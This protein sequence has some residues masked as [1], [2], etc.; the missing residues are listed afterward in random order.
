MANTYASGST[1]KLPLQLD[2]TGTIHLLGK[3]VATTIDYI[4]EVRQPPAVDFVQREKNLEYSN[5]SIDGNQTIC[6][7]R[8]N[9]IRSLCVVVAGRPDQGYL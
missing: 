9:I 2:V 3:H 4:S 5:P 7:M 8:W 6:S 1:R